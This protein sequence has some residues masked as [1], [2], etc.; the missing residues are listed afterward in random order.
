MSEFSANEIGEEARVKSDWKVDSHLEEEI[1]TRL[2][3]VEP[4]LMKSERMKKSTLKSALT[5]RQRN[6]LL[7]LSVNGL[8]NDH[9]K[10]YKIRPDLNHYV[11]ARTMM[12]TGIRLGETKNLIIPHVVFADEQPMIVI[13]PV[14]PE[15]LDDPLGKI[16]TEWYPK[17]PSSRRV[18]PIPLDLAQILKEYIGK[19]KKGYVFH[20]Q[21]LQPFSKRGIRKFVN[22][23]SRNFDSINRNTGVHTLRRTY[24]SYLIKKNADLGIVSKNLGHKNIKTTWLYLFNIRDPDQMSESARIAGSIHSIKGE[25]ISKLMEKGK[26]KRKAKIKKE[27]KRIKKQGKN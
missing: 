2:A 26:A 16:Y 20:S 22:R 1:K 6:E 23:L 13:N 19:R 8:K 10:R 7:E 21:R 4:E 17:T 24:A 18:V 11:I 27:I 25:K 15:K 5:E 9:N 14:I 12:E 3:E